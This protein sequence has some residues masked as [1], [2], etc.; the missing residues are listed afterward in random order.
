MDKY[1]K[2]Y[3]KYKSKYLYLRGGTNIKDRIQVEL[4]K[5]NSTYFNW[6]YFICDPKTHFILNTL[7]KK[8]FFRLQLDD[9]GNIN[10][11][12]YS[13]GPHLHSKCENFKLYQKNS[14]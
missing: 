8:Q 10:H 3:N 4:D 12:D 1:L 11:I 5:Q 9:Y 6:T 2:K 7:D 13:N 14:N